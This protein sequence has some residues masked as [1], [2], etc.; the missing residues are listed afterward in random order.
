[1]ILDILEVHSN[2]WIYLNTMELF[3]SNFFT[4]QNLTPIL[5]SYGHV[6]KIPRDD[7]LHS[8]P[9]TEVNGNDP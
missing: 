6:T 8:E 5:N 3:L 1:M 2:W 7:G 4:D 9:T